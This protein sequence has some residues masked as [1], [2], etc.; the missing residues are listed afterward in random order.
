MVGDGY[1]DAAALTAA[2]LGIAMGSGTDVAKESGDMVL[3]QGGL[4]KVIEALQVSRATFAIIRQNLFWAFAYNLVALPLAIFAS[5]PPTLAALAMS[6]SSI[7]VVLNALR[8]Y[9][10]RF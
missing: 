3:I 2:D 1:N 4:Y 5:V 8:L 10:K 9:G 7:S 6:L